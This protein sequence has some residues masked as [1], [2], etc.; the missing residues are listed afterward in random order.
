MIDDDYKDIVTQIR[1]V[2]FLSTPHRGTDL[3][4]MLNRILSV[5]LSIY[6]PK[7]YISEL[8]RNSPALE[9][10]NE[11]FRNVASNLDVY[12]FYETLE[13]AVGP[14]RVVGVFEHAGL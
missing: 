5:S 1:S 2:L 13:T 9:D 3:A 10:I 14:R 7:N 12:S 8:N 6:S 4:E 11:T